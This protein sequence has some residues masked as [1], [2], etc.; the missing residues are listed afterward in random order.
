MSQVADI[1]RTIQDANLSP[2]ELMQL[3]DAV[4]GEI[5]DAQRKLARRVAAQLSTGDTVRIREDA[6]LRPRYILGTE[7]EVMEIKQRNA[8]IK[9]GEVRGPF[10]GKFRTGQIIRCPMDALEP[11]DA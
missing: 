6:N 7:A 4:G 11:V 8:T 2:D 10:N 5:K 1:I 9:L 3:R